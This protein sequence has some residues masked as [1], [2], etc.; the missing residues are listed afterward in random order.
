MYDAGIAQRCL[1]PDE[2][3]PVVRPRPRRRQFDEMPRRQRLC[4]E[5]VGQHR[6][7]C[8]GFRHADENAQVRRSHDGLHVRCLAEDVLEEGPYQRQGFVIGNAG[9][10]AQEFGGHGAR[11]GALGDGWRRDQQQSLPTQ[12]GEAVDVAVRP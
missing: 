8:S 3:E 5:I 1:V 9:K 7:S 10:P 2:I 4:T 6:P 11:L 12:L